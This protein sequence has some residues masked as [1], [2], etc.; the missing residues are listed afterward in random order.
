MLAKPAA[1]RYGSAPPATAALRAAALR[2]WSAGTCRRPRASRLHSLTEPVG[3]LRARTVGERVGH[4]RARGA[5]HHL[6]VADLCRR[7]QAG[8]DVAAIE[9]AAGLLRVMR[10]HARIAVG[11]QLEPH[12][13]LVGLALAD[14][15]LRGLHL[16]HRAQQV[17]D[18][19]ADLVGDDVG[20][21][22]LA[23]RL[24]LLR[25]HPVEA[26]VDVDRL[27]VRAVERAGGGLAG[28]AGGR[29]RAVEHHELGRPVLRAALAED[30]LPDVLGAGKDHRGEAP[31]LVLHR[32]AL[33]LDLRLLLG[34]APAELARAFHQAEH[35]H[36][37]DAE[38]PAAEQRDDQRADAHAAGAP[39]GHPHASAIFDVVALPSVFPAHAR[40][41]RGAPPCMADS[42]ARL[43]ARRRAARRPARIIAGAGL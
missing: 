14:A 27:V 22:E 10:P 36:R 38:Q 15:L 12:R 23:R 43:R 25:Q 3:A 42:I 18:V 16:L 17:L 39:A 28:A 11:L 8:L 34:G 31:A 37:V 6:V 29:R 21:G 40:S 1:A 4:H 20:I 35:H 5:P 30:L 13:Q 7:V 33:A 2:A 9:P 32:A 19:V 26:E 41:P 24:E